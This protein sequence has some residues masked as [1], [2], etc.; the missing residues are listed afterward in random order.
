MRTDTG[1]KR[2]ACAIAFVGLL[3]AV[4]LQ[5]PLGERMGGIYQVIVQLATLI[6]FYEVVK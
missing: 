5:I 1:A 3:F 4:V 6:A 2:I